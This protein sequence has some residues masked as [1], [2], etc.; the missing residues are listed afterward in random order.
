MSTIENAGEEERTRAS[1]LLI[2]ENER[3]NVATFSNIPHQR[4]RVIVNNDH[5]CQV[6]DVKHNK[7]DKK[8]KQHLSRSRDADIFQVN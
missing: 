1:E 3:K 2:Q 5:F 6:F 8:K 7:T 4:G